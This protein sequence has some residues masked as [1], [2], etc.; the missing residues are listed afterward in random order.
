MKIENRGRVTLIALAAMG[1]GMA[2]G[3]VATQ[4]MAQGRQR[5]SKAR[6]KAETLIEQE[7]TDIEGYV[8]RMQELDLDPASSSGSHRHDAHVFVYVV[9]GEIA[10]RVGE[11]G[12]SIAYKA[13]QT[14]Y[15][16]PNAVH[17]E[18]RNTSDTERAK[19]IALFI[20]ES[21]KPMTVPVFAPTPGG[22]GH[23]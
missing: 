4:S 17:G 3:G 11:D 22:H 9:A 10:S 19:A 18:F 8:V 20:M 6:L 13:G 23:D 12:E 7:L 21:G 1:L 2:L 5:A 15:E 16:P 14:W